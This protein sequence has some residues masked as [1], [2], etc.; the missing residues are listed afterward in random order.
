MNPL[1]IKNIAFYK[2]FRPTF[3]LAVARVALRD[4]MRE[5]EIKGTL[6]ISPEGI[7]GSFAG[8]PEKTDAFVKFLLQIIGIQN[9]RHLPDSPDL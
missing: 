2:F 9:W 4:R 7:N 3:D 8:S 6:L 1:T 5:L